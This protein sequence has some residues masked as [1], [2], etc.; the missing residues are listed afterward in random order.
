MTLHQQILITPPSL[1]DLAYSRSN[2]LLCEY[3]AG[4]SSDPTSKQYSADLAMEWHTMAY[5]AAMMNNEIPLID[6]AKQ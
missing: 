6:L 2:A 5:L 1:S 3:R 4:G